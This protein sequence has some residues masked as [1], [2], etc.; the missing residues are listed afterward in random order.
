MIL[1]NKSLP[2]DTDRQTDRHIS[3]SFCFLGECRRGHR[4]F[5]KPGRSPAPFER[6]LEK[7]KKNVMCLG[8]KTFN[9]TVLK[10]KTS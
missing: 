2:M 7:G 5:A 6:H 4:A 8:I 9:T 10:P 1:S 3:Y